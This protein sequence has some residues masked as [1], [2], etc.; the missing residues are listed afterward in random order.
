MANISERTLKD[1]TKRY[2]VIIRIK[3]SESRT[4]TFRRLTDAKKWIAK[5]ES[6]IRDGKQL[7]P[8]AAAK[9][10]LGDAI[11][12]YISEVLPTKPKLQVDQTTQLNWFKSELGEVPLAN[13]TTPLIV[14]CRNKLNTEMGQRGKVR[15][16]ATVVRHLAALSA[17]FS[18]CISEWEWTRDNPVKRVKKPTVSNDRVRFLDDNERQRFLKACQESSNKQLY[19]CVI[20]AMSSGMR[21]AELMELTWKDLDLKAG[22]LLLN[23]TKNGEKR[24]VPLAGHGLELL[25]DHAKVRRLD[26]PMLFPSKK[27]PLNP[28]DLRRPFENAVRLAEIED[29]H[30][31]D[32]RHCCASYLLMNGASLPE[33]AKVLGHKSLAMVMRYSHMSDDHAGNVVASMNQKIFGGV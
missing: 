21:Q 4:E 8:R 30:W 11:D 7:I 24:R 29:F 17:M 13:V 2:T 20:L 31:H 32:L 15:S 6:E 23:E 28:I 26:T 14:D 1:G 18:H 25:R 19:L 12:R 27:N 5:T 3:G 33:I 10:T 9:K 22:F 16:P